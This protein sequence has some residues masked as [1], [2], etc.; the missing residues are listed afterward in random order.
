MDL[1]PT[2]IRFGAS[3]LRRGQAGGQGGGNDPDSI[4]VGAEKFPD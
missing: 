1:A 4:V 2:D 3:Y